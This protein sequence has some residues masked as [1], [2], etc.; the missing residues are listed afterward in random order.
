[1]SIELVLV[2]F[3]LETCPPA[4]PKQSHHLPTLLKEGGLYSLLHNLPI[5]FHILVNIL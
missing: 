4:H 3:G 1:M 5:T 2:G